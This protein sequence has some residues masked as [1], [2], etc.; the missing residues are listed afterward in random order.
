LKEARK[1]KKPGTI[2]QVNGNIRIESTDGAVEM[3]RPTGTFP[4]V[5]GLIRNSKPEPDAACT[6]SLDAELLYRLA[7]AI[8]ANRSHDNPKG[9]IVRLWIADKERAIY[10]DGGVSNEGFGLLM[11]YRS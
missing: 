8:G 11:P 3:P 9:L 4:N 5:E 1:H 2:I 7:R 6:I 10:I